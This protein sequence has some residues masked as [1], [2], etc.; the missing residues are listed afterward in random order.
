MSIISRLLLLFGIGASAEILTKKAMGLAGRERVMESVEAF[1]EALA[2]DPLYVPA[3]DGLGK[4]YFRMGFRDQ[5][6]R[7]FA[8][9]DG[10]DTLRIDPDNLEKGLKM[11]RAMMEKGL[12]QLVVTHTEHLLKLN[13]RHADLL[14][15][16]GLSYKALGNDSRA[17]QLLQTGLER[18]TRDPDFYLHL[19]SL[20]LRSGS[21]EE[22]EQLT[23][24]ARLLGRIVA[25]PVDAASRVTLARYFIKRRKLSEAAEYMR[26]AVAIEPNNAEYWLELAE[27]YIESGSSPAAADAFRKATR[28][29]PADPRPQKGLARA[30][31][32]LGRTEESRAAKELA[33]VLEGGQGEAENAT[34]GA[35][36]IKYL[37]SINE[38]ERAESGLRDMLAKWPDSLDLKLIQARLLYKDQ[39]F[40]EALAMLKTVVQ[41]KEKS[42]EA[43]IWMAMS[44]QRLGD[45]MSALAEGQ[46][47]I[48]LAPKSHVAHK[49]LGDIYRE[50]KKFSMAENA[51]ETAEN[52]KSAKTKK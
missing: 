51:Y 42:A 36:F 38:F 32:Q 35:R 41:E 22:G 48:R 50:Q 11:G 29:I 40:E 9:A 46:L 10:L 2:Q 15:M 14:K 8:I 3:Y 17:R 44:Y 47:A 39:K 33:A 37:L 20:E 31:L 7:E 5:A 27:T 1:K 28:L 26:Q 43:H 18:W 21:K 34:K 16:L 12:H 24:M 23:Q 25:D 45:T 52:L 19:G 49:V 30:Y 4:L 13:P 6:D